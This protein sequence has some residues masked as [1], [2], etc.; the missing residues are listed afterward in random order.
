MILVYDRPGD[1]DIQGV[2]KYSVHPG[3]A[4]MQKAFAGLKAKTGRSMDEWVA[5][6]KKHG[7]AEIGARRAWLKGEGLT[8][9]YAWWVAD[10]VEGR[11]AEDTD[12]DAYLS[13]AARWVEDMFAGNK[14]ALRPAYDALLALALAAGKDTK[15]CPCKT[16]VPIYRE[17]VFAQIKPA[18]RTR[19]DLGLYLPGETA[20][21]RLIDTGGQAKGDRITH[22]V[23]ITAP[24][25]IDDRVRKWV[26]KA[27]EQAA[28]KTNA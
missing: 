6:A 15:A 27:Y 26:K 2:I 4:T 7:P 12:P 9:N 25:D 19:I 5:H 3:V 1:W 21:S 16:I 20:T 17:H 24:G 13:A 10:R 28:P 23:A 11:G 8:T 14:A 18:T 22:R